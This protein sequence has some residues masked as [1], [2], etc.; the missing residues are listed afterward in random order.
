MKTTLLV[1]LASFLFTAGCGE[2][3]EKLT[4]GEEAN[5]LFV[6]SI[7]LID[8]ARD[9]F[10]NGNNDAAIES[11]KEVKAKV[12][13]I[14]NE[15]SESNLAVKIIQQE[16]MF[17]GNT[18]NQIKN[19]SNNI[20]TDVEVAERER[21]AEEQA[22]IRR[23]EARRIHKQQE[24]KR[25]RQQK[26]ADRLKVNADKGDN[27][28]RYKLAQYYQTKFDDK[29][30][31]RYFQLAAENGH[32]NAQEELGEMMLKGIK[33]VI[34]PSTEEGAGWYEKAAKQGSASAQ[35]KLAR[36]YE[37]GVGV[38]RD[39]DQAKKWASMSAY[40]LYGP[41]VSYMERYHLDRVRLQGVYFLGDVE[42][43]PHKISSYAWTLVIEFY[44]LQRVNHNPKYNFPIRPLE[45]K[46]LS[47]SQMKEAEQLAKNIIQKLE[48]AK[49]AKK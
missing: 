29:E 28:A 45:K 7:K 35:F 8:E 10:G 23:D 6:G 32:I 36:I 37:S 42:R 41:G 19:E 18:W 27:E 4:P 24:A 43:S 16:P 25:V 15:Y 9:Q 49:K 48:V 38:E 39:L 26:E 22:K 12:N 47:V 34:L 21:L 1:L 40:Q 14:L 2:P 17:G 46:E 20:L 13:R 5:K 3:V 30:S 44:G 11:F 31:L 33:G